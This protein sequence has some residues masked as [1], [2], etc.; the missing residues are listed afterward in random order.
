VGSGHYHL[1]PFFVLL[2]IPFLF[3]E[4]DSSRHPC[5]CILRGRERVITVT[6]CC[7]K[8]MCVHSGHGF[9]VNYN[10][11]W[12]FAW[13]FLSSDFFGIGLIFNKNHVYISSNEKKVEKLIK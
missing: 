2:F 3:K 6:K 1:I 12:T 7:A 4:R 11:N 13:G 10:V 9:C 5:L 8:Y